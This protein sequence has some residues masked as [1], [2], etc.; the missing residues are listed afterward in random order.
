MIVQDLKIQSVSQQ[1][2]H[3]WREGLGEGEGNA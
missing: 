3:P 1:A 2:Y